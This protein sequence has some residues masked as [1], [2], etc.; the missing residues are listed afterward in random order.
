MEFNKYRGMSLKENL[1]VTADAN[2]MMENEI[3]RT[4]SCVG[5][6]F[7]NFNFFMN[8]TMRIVAATL[9]ANVLRDV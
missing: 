1:P 9:P 5:I 8:W 4:S 7:I 2:V 6:F 3:I